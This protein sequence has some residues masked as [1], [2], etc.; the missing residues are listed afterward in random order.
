MLISSSSSIRMPAY[1]PPRGLGVRV[2][3]NPARLTHRATGRLCKKYQSRRL[4]ES[5]IPAAS[6][7]S[8]EGSSTS[9]LQSAVVETARKIYSFVDAQFLPVALL[10]ALT[11]G[12]FQPE[13]AVAARDAGI[14]NVATLVI[15]I[16]SGA[17]STG[18][19]CSVCR[20]REL[21]T[22]QDTNCQE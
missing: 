6:P 14:G 2:P 9:G 7:D 16:L 19:V 22:Q 3:G 8:G 21:W 17:L 20:G 11:A 10:S 5:C 12:Y 18:P 1:T 13:V 15:F 4:K